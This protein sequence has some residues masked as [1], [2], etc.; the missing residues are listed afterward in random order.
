[1]TRTHDVVI[2]GAGIM[3][4]SSAFE[5]AKR[6]LDVAVVDKGHVGHGPS[7]RSSAIIRQHYSNRLTARMALH[8]LRVFQDFEARVGDECGFRRTGCV[9]LVA[10][11]DRAGLEANVALHQE[12][13]IGT[14]VLAPEALREIMPGLAT[15]GL[16]AAAY[17]PESGYADPHL[18]VNT[19][20]Q[21]A[22]RLGATVLAETEV[23]GVRFTGGKVV[24]VET[25]GGTLAAPR[26]VNCAGAWGARV[27][28]MAGVE[29]P[30]DACRVQ[31]AYFRRPSGHQAPHPVVLDF[32]HATYFRS[33]GDDLT[34]AGLVDP[35]EAG[36]VVDPDAYDDGVDFDFVSDVG[37]RLVR[38]YPAMEQGRS[39]GG[40]ASL[41]AVT[42]DWH[43]VIDEVPAG[44]GFYL[45]S[46]FSGHGF[47]L[48]PAVG[49]MVADLV[50]GASAPVF[51]PHLFRLGRYGE[52]DPVRGRYEYSIVG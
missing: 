22:R 18:T 8:S 15:A 50:T 12:V 9:V 24:G 31:V 49:L 39:T 34:L 14:E 45:C 35:A 11:A 28:R 46:G 23:T 51:D 19:Y 29:V 27:A 25:P 32:I 47:K 1:M 16:V 6:G 17:E 37:A 41:Y 52:D 44:S 2:I 21:A 36:A 33:E 40:Y 48:G 4:A 38:R 30:I 20:A 10:A 5:L 7:G 42:P 43:P 3:G 13:G 26:V